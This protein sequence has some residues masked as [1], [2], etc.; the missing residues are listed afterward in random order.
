MLQHV[1]PGNSDLNSGADWSTAKGTIAAALAALPVGTSGQPIG[2]I[3]LY[4]GTHSLGTTTLSY[5]YGDAVNDGFVLQGFGEGLTTVVY[6]G[7]TKAFEPANFLTAEMKRYVKFRGFTLE[8]TDAD[9]AIDAT[10][11]NHGLLEHLE[12]IGRSATTSVKS[13]SIGVL[14]DGSYGVD[15]GCWFNDL[16]RYVISGF[17]TGVKCTGSV[18]TGQANQNRIT[19]GQVAKYT[20]C[21]VDLD[22]GDNIIVEDNDLTLGAVPTVAG[23][24]SNGLANKILRN[25]FEGIDSGGVCVLIDGTG[26]K[27]GDRDIVAYNL[28]ASKSGSKAIVEASGSKRTSIGPNQYSVG[29]VQWTD[30]STA[31]S[32]SISGFGSSD[33]PNLFP[34]EFAVANLAA[35]RASSAI[36][37]LGMAAGNNKHYLQRPFEIRGMT[38]KALNAPT[39]GSITAVLTFGGV[40][41]TLSV[42]LGVGATTA[43]AWEDMQV[44]FNAGGSGVGVNVSTTSTLTPVGAT[45][46]DLLVD[47]WVEFTA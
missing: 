23:I 6:T 5:G 35:G 9:L 15:I 7:T 43:G 14:F 12:I 45:H 18:S 25:R 29:V 3:L 26:T 47:V 4:P 17:E 11:M 19:R 41:Q 42:T 33:N 13:G 27:P 8:A 36:D 38:L 20:R 28:F 34:L 30:A 31:S 40:A 2:V 1:K 44:D 22:V 16:D 37:V 21:G 10:G 39:A 24:R 32:T 46:I